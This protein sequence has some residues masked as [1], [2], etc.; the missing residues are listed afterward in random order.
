MATFSNSELLEVPSIAIIFK[1]V[2]FYIPHYSYMFRNLLAI[3]KRN[4][5]LIICAIASNT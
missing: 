2:Y 3:L 1:Y 5:Q 4:I